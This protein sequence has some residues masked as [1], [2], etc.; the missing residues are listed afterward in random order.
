M[1]DNRIGLGV[2][3][4]IASAAISCTPKLS[5][6]EL[7]SSKPP[8]TREMTAPGLQSWADG[9]AQFG[10]ELYQAV[11]KEN[12]NL[13]ISPFSVSCMLA[14]LFPAAGEPTRSEIAEILQIPTEFDVPEAARR[15]RERAERSPL[16]LSASIWTQRDL[17]VSESYLDTLAESFDAGVQQV[18]FSDLDHA[19][20]QI[21]R[22]VKRQTE[23]A[24][25]NVVSPRNL[26]PPILAV[27]VD[28]IRFVGHWELPFEKSQTEPSEFTMLDG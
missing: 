15:S 7:K 28:T 9:T 4:A 17:P 26:S 21:N 10:Y 16:Q 12:G 6:T 13:F 19:C 27:L 1:N 20:E 24:F 3:I 22:W 8:R 2:C 11:P 23:G 18:D 5:V 14:M 25:D